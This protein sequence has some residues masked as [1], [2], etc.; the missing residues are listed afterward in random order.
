MSQNVYWMLELDLKA[1]RVDDFRALMDEMVTATRENEPG[2][3]G[4]EW[5][6][7][8]DGTRCH[9]FEHYANSDATMVH[10]GNFAEKFAARFL[11]ILSPTKFVVYGYPDR[12]VREALAPF[13]ATYMQPV[14]G[15]T[16]QAPRIGGKT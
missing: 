11:D 14:G 7:D 8:D 4:Y 1:G 10:L 16:R 13:G 3:L 5:S 6:L 12:Q 2:A 9:I 15:F